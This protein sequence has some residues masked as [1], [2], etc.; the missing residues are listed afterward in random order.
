MTI[1]AIIGEGPVTYKAL[2]AALGELDRN[3]KF[4]VPYGKSESLE[5]VYDWLIENEKNFTVVGAAT[6][7]LKSCAEEVID[8]EDGEN[9][10]AAIID[11]ISK[12]AASATLLVLWQDDVLDDYIMQAAKNGLKILELSNGLTPIDVLDDD[13]ALS[14]VQEPQD[15]SEE[16][17]S[18]TREELES[19]PVA[20]VKRFA[21]SKGFDIS[22]MKKDEIID[23]VFA[24]REKEAGEPPSAPEEKTVSS[25]SDI[26]DALLAIADA[27]KKL[28][29]CF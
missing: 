6:R 14:P 5:S 28:S 11:I 10:H 18:F 26:K 21:V 15:D 23:L 12:M 29:D 16:V 3:A 19:M 22:G 9:P 25:S 2:A 27:I 1:Y 20:A 13:E 7:G 8:L 24:P 17:E 4:I